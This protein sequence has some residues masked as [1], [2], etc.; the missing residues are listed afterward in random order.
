MLTWVQAGARGQGG[1]G[2]RG[3]ED[4]GVRTLLPCPALPRPSQCPLHSTV[5]GTGT[6][7]L[8]PFCFASGPTRDPIW[9]PSTQAIRLRRHVKHHAVY[10][11][12]EGPQPILSQL[13]PLPNLMFARHSCDIHGLAALHPHGSNLANTRSTRPLNTTATHRLPA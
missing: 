5:P 13:T 7:T 2:D 6:G 8:Y 4:V 1:Q 3:E 11:N 10:I 12:P 9:G